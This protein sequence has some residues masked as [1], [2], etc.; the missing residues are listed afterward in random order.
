[1]KFKTPLILFFLVF[2]LILATPTSAHNPRLVFDQESSLDKPFLITQPD[3][4]QAF[5]GQLRGAN[6]YYQVNLN[7]DQAFYFQ[8]LVPD[9]PNIQKNISAELIN[10][11]TQELITTLKPEE[12]TWNNFYEPFGGDNYWQGPEATINLLAGN[13]LIKVFNPNNDGKYVLVVGQKESFPLS[14]IIRT[15]RDLPVL[16]IY[17]DRSPLTAYFNYSGLFLG[18]SLLILVILVIVIRLIY[19]KFKQHVK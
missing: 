1:M 12:A 9:V 3:I 18:A 10:L 19:R 16:K 14:E 6:D 15:T 5:Y 13:Y 7:S 11:N 17:F 8:I 4:S 2:L